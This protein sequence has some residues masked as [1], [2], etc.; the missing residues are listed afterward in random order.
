MISP[1]LKWMDMLN[2]TVIG[3]MKTVLVFI[4]NVLAPNIIGS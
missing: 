1:W 3:D 2:N 4:S